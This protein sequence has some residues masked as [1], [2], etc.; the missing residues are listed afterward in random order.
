M[1]TLIGIAV[2]DTEENDRTQYTWK[3]LEALVKTVDLTK[4]R[5]IVSDNGSCQATIDCYIHFKDFLDII[6]NKSN[7]GTARA[8]NNVLRLRNESENFIKMDND[9]V[10]H[11]IGWVDQLETVIAK[12]NSIGILGLKRKDIWQHPLH[13]NPAYKTYLEA[14][15]HEAGEKW[16]NIEVCTDIMGSCTM[17][18]DR[19]IQ[20]V[21]FLYQSGSYAFDDT[22]MSYRSHLAGFKNAFLPHIEI[23][24]IDAGGNDYMHWKHKVAGEAMADFNRRCE[25]YKTGFRPLYYDGGFND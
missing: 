6:Y 13:E 25:E 9:I 16:L 1:A 2:W 5:I 11:E 20:E 4:H 12:D 8:I 3:T 15:P 18:S 7:I 21:G 14:L 19:L 17:F 24:H 22:D 23:D 10:V